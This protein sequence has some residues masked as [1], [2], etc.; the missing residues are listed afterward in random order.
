MVLISESE[1]NEKG[2][3]IR[4]SNQFLLNYSKLLE[5]KVKEISPKY[6]SEIQKINPEVPL[7]HIPFYLLSSP[8]NRIACALKG[9]GIAINTRYLFENQKK[10]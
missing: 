9:E 10:R 1:R 2:G 8:V 7:E 3:V 6:M 5:E 4:E